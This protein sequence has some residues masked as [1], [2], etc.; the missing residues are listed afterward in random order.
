M[1]FIGAIPLKSPFASLQTAAL[2]A[3][4]ASGLLA[5]QAS[6]GSVVFDTS[7]GDIV[8]E[9][10]EDAA[11]ETVENFL[12]YVERGDY[13][14][15]IIHRSVPGFV[16]Q[17]GGFVPGVGDATPVAIPVLEPVVNEPG[18]SNT[19]GTIALARV[20]GQVDSGTSQFFFNLD[21]SNSFLDTVDEG[22]TV[23]GEISEGQDVVDAIAALGITNGPAAPFGELPFLN[24][25][26]TPPTSFSEVDFVLINSGSVVEDPVVVVTDPVAPIDPIDPVGGP[27]DPVQPPAD[28]DGGVAAVPSPSAA[29]AGLLG[30]G[31]LAT[32]RRRHD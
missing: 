12:G 26:S 5:G 3:C 13:D 25:I 4:T 7:L 6:A 1:P 27:V 30:L 18:I 14:G 22:F 32:R 8:I 11:P 28:D 29:V 21:D 23:F 9:L 20:G 17:G 16:V 19:R 10:F 31:A 2:A 15:T 24:D